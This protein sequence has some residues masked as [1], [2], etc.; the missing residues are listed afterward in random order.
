MINSN[1]K[2][3]NLTPQENIFR[4]FILKNHHPARK[5]KFACISRKSLL[6]TF[7]MHA[8]L[9]QRDVTRFHG[10]LAPKIADIENRLPAL[11]K[12]P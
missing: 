1:L 9:T 2:T 4:Y 10:L 5:C 8:L 3:I 11:Y 7:Y 12:L 6:N